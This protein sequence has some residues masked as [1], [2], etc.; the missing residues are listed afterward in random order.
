MSAKKVFGNKDLYQ[1]IQSYKPLTG[2]EK[3]NRK[4]VILE[5]KYQY[6]EW[7]S[8]RRYCYICHSHHPL[9]I[10]RYRTLAQMCDE[11]KAIVKNI[12]FVG[13]NMFV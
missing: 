9:V 6:C 2:I 1:L 8:H 7:S 3:R 11:C 4:K 13:V 12:L 10:K 5:L